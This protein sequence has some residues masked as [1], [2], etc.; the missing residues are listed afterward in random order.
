MLRTLIRAQ[1]CYLLL[2]PLSPLPS[3]RINIL[4]LQTIAAYPALS[5]MPTFHHWTMLRVQP[6]TRSLQRSPRAPPF[7]RERRSVY[8]VA[9]SRCRAARGMSHSSALQSCADEHLAPRIISKLRS[10]LGRC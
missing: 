9:I 3:S 4:M 10:D 7:R 5:H 1:V 2:P 8:G 6:S